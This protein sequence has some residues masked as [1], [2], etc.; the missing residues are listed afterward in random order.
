MIEMIDVIIPV[1]NTPIKDLERCL[2]SVLNQTFN[3][4]VVYIIDDGSNIETKTYLDNYIKD[5]SNFIVKHIKNGGVS[6][7]RNLGLDIS[8]NEYI[9]FVDSDDTLNKDFL[10]EAYGLIKENNLD[11]IIGGYNEIIDNK[12]TRVRISMSGIHIYEK[13]TLNNFFEKL[14]SGKT[15]ETN[16]EIGDCPTGRIYTRLFK[17]ASLKNLR[18]NSNIHSEDTLFMIDYMKQVKKIGI[19]DKVWY[20]Y[21]VNEYSIS[22]GTKTD[23]LINNIEG[24][25]NEVTKRCDKESNIRIKKAYKERIEKVNNYIDELKKEKRAKQSI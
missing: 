19:T 9:T 25:I 3:K 17:R 7:A 11:L 14:L 23:K 6:N 1:Y 10:K 8:N 15:N 22:N 4:Y 2:N 20:N 18:F 16:K 21:Y 24:F 12:I 5:K 13:N